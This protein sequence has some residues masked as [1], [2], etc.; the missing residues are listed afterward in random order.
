MKKNLFL[1]VIFSMVFHLSLFGKEEIRFGVF[2]YLGYEKTKAKYEPLVEYLNS[3]LEKKVVLEVLTQEQMDQKILRKELDIATT[4][5]TH[6]LV[7]RHNTHLSGAIATLTQK[8][9]GQVLNSLGGVILVRKDSQI[10]TIS[11]IRNKKIATPSLKHMGGFRAQAHE[12]HKAGIEI[13]KENHIVVVDIHQ[14][15]VEKMLKKEV[16][17]AFVRDGIIEK[18]AYTGELTLDDVRI[19]NE[20]KNTN[21]P[22]KVSTTLYPEWPVFALPYAD[23]TDVK[24]LLAALFSFDGDSI[25]GKKSEIYGYDLPAD[26]LVVEEMSRALRL[27]PYESIGIINYYDIWNQ[28]KTDILLLACVL[29]LIFFY[30]V[31]TKRQNIF[32]DSLLK[33][34]GDGVYGVDRDGICI[35][36]NQRALDMLGYTKNEVIGHNQHHLFH[37]HTIANESYKEEDCPIYKTIKDKIQRECTEFFIKKNGEHFPVALAVAAADHYGAIVVFRDITATKNY[38]E[39]LKYE[40]SKKTQELQEL[41]SELETR[42]SEAIEE[43]KKQQSMLEQ[44]ARLAAL[45]EMI[46]NIAHQW[47]QPLSVITTTISSLQLRQQ[48]GVPMTEIL[49]EETANSIIR[50][51]NY[52]SKTIDDFRDFIRNDDKEEVF[53]LSV[54]VRDTANLLDATLRSN[55]IDLSLE[56]DDTLQYK[57]KPSQ[58]SQVLMNIISNARDAFTRYEQEMKK[59]KVKTFLSGTTIFIEVIDNAGGIDPA[60]QSKIFDPYFTTKHKSRGTGLGLYMSSNIIEKYFD[61]TIRVENTSDRHDSEHKGT[62]FIIEFAQNL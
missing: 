9:D 40:V 34:I 30:I 28:N 62:K 26:Y 47:R 22:F 24:N 55:Q 42:I 35:W 5:P 46:G 14:T 54:V 60:I 13:L 41:N 7:I 48:F 4:N 15:G 45:G 57:G 52:L 31:R 18:M 16:D 49:I 32:I 56:L 44:Q 21:H 58:L 1:V 61:G 38:E 59:I 33:N 19:I 27:P 12:F 50:Q 25:Y 10:N 11:D 39:K 29:V 6:F 20:Q 23:K 43:N 51:A 3:K 37:H 8:I 17:V 2:A 53:L 36:I